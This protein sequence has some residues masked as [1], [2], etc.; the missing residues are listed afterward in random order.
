M[1]RYDIQPLS[2]EDLTGP[3]LEGV[4]RV[5]GA[6]LGFSRADSRVRAQESI[7][8]RH[9]ER[10]GFRAF[11]AFD[12]SKL[13]GFSYGYASQPGLW[14]REQ[15]WA[16]LSPEQRDHWFAD[17]FEVCELHVHPAHQGHMLG[18]RLHDTLLADLP[19]QTA[20]LSVMHKSQRARHLYFSRGWQMLIEELR[21]SSDPLT[22]FSILGLAL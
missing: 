18:G 11:G 16:A 1:P 14:W 4:L 19:H 20:L 3:V 7:T 6:A 15:V 21:F 12:D 10:G 2:A 13:V 9:A 22:P 8:R 17:A 5:F